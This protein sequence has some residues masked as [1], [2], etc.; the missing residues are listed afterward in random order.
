MMSTGE[1]IERIF[2]E[3][4]IIEVPSTTTDIVAAGLLDSLALVTLLFEVEQEF[5]VSVPL[6]NLDIESLRTVE[7]IEALVE[8]LGAERDAIP[9]VP[10]G[11]RS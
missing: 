2:R 11:F 3:V 7:R 6:E 9:P 10:G 1:R 8:R 5:A 4:L